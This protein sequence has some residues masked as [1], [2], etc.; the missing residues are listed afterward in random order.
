MLNGCCWVNEQYIFILLV[1]DL[2]RFYEPNLF[3]HSHSLFPGS[4]AA[5]PLIPGSKG[6]LVLARHHDHSSPQVSR[7]K[8]KI[9]TRRCESVAHFLRVDEIQNQRHSAGSEKPS[10]LILS[11]PS[12]FSWP[13][14]L[15]DALP[16]ESSLRFI[17]SYL[18]LP[19][20]INDVRSGHEA[21]AFAAQ[22]CVEKV[23]GTMGASLT[24]IRIISKKDSD[25]SNLDSV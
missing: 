19:L 15:A 12:I 8:L 10:F 16:V 4:Q 18:C 11:R 2:V 25:N 6:M 9:N 7:P 22:T 23:A 21:R 13:N 1:P 20:S 3:Q 5:S 24:V 17:L 14:F